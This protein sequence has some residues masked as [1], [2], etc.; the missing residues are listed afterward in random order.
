MQDKPVKRQFVIGSEWLYYKIYCGVSVANDVLIN[1]IKPIT[2]KLIE[3]KDI[4]SWFFIRY[5][6]PESHLRVRFLLSN[7]DNLSTLILLLNKEFEYYLNNHLVWDLQL[8]TYTREIERYGANTIELTEQLFY[9]DS[10][11]TIKLIENSN[12]DKH[13]L[14]YALKIVKRLLNYSELDIEEQLQ[15]VENQRTYFKGEFNANKQTIKHLNSKY[16]TIKND[17]FKESSSNE[18][19][20]TT[21]IDSIKPIFETIIDLKTR[22]ELQFTLQNYIASIIHMKV[23]RLFKTK[24]R[25]Y[26][27]VLYDFLYKELKTE[28]FRLK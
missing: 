14:L 10:V 16:K 6:D 26:E 18:D 9:F 2:Q 28:K 13:L 12:D 24:Q 5:N 20:F 17:F 22:N 19:F 15:F 11:N 27:F 1:V 7:S 4:K 23:N 25:F 21:Y 3:N 8:H